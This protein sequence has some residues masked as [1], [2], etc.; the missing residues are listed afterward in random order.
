M[1]SPEEFEN[2]RE[3]TKKEQK[4]TTFF[5]LFGMILVSYDR[6][7]ATLLAGVE[8]CVSMVLYIL[9]GLYLTKKY[10]IYYFS[11]F[12]FFFVEINV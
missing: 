4:K 9:G 10:F 5:D 6:Q 12:F 8:T 11:F 2:A 3:D 7:M 1:N